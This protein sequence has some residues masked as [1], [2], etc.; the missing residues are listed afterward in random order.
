MSE[1]QAATPV[2]EKTAEEKQAA[3]KA[4]AE[5]GQGRLRAF[6]VGI[7]QLCEDSGVSRDKLAKE[8]GVKPDALASAL[9]DSMAQAA[10]QNEGTAQ[11]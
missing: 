5:E 8:A 7:G 3:E 10:E 6:S 1:G 9:V 2:A 11:K 4:A